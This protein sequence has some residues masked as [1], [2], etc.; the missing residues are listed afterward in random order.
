M[1][2]I[3]KNQN[4][5]E[6]NISNARRTPSLNVWQYLA[7]VVLYLAIVQGVAAVLNTGHQASH[8][9]TSV[10]NIIRSIIIP[11]GLASAFTLAVVSW[12]GAWKEIF[13]NRLPVKRWLIA[14]PIILFVTAAV[15][16]NYPGLS[17]KGLEF[18]LLL[19][20]GTLMVGFGEE[21]MF[22]GL[23]VLAYRN[24]GYSEFKVGLWTT[25]IFAGAHATNIF[26][27]GPSALIQVLATAGTGLIFYFILR[28]SGALFVAMTAH[29]LWD[30][31]VLSSQINPD[32]P[33]PLVNV[34]AIVLIGMLIALFIFR[35]RIVS[36][37]KS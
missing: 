12:L 3:S 5:T 32:K 37:K 23:G 9:P 16:T 33:W 30:F 22:R 25:L 34:S 21:L 26:T 10:E 24:S 1:P 4:D 27:A 20:V 28:S 19:L 36:A 11:V 2:D 14:I 7:F 8:A 31:S 18:T 17:E 13:T 15:I 29:G 35:K 6:I